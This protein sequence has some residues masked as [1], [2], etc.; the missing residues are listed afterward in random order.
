MDRGR[1]DSG[2]GCSDPRAANTQRPQSRVGGQQEEADGVSDFLPKPQFWVNPSLAFKM[3]FA[4]PSP[5]HFTVPACRAV[6][7]HL[8]GLITLAPPPAS[9]PSLRL[10]L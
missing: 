10:S 5:V 2:V 9:P 1:E 4:Y 8:L 6:P 3:I 7:L